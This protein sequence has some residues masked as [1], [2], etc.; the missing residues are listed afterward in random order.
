VTVSRIFPVSLTSASLALAACAEPDSI[1]VD[2][3][4][5]DDV[6]TVPAPLLGCAG[7]LADVPY[8][9]PLRDNAEFLDISYMDS[10]NGMPDKWGNPAVLPPGIPAYPGGGVMYDFNRADDEPAG[11]SS[12]H[13]HE[14]G[15]RD[16]MGNDTSYD[17]HNGYD[18]MPEP[19][20]VIDE[21]G[22]LVYPMSPGVVRDVRYEG[23]QMTIEV[24]HPNDYFTLYTHLEAGTERV[25]D[26][27]PV[28]LNTALAQLDTNIL[29]NGDANGHLHFEVHDCDPDWEPSYVEVFRADMQLMKRKPLYDSGPSDASDISLAIGDAPD[30]LAHDVFRVE[31]GDEL[32][33]RG[34][35]HW[36]TG[37]T[38]SVDVEDPNG[39][40]HG[41]SQA[42]RTDISRHGRFVQPATYTIGASD[43]LGLW[44]AR[45]TVNGRVRQ[46]KYFEVVANNAAPDTNGPVQ[47]AI[48]AVSSGPN[49]V[50]AY[51]RSTSGRMRSRVWREGTTGWGLSDH[52]GLSLAGPPSC[53]QRSA[54]LVDCFYR[55]NDQHFYRWASVDG[56]VTGTATD[57]Y[58]ASTGSDPEAFSAGPTSLEIAFND[59]GVMSLLH[60]NGS[61]FTKV[62]STQPVAQSPS[63]VVSDATHWLCYARLADTTAR[64]IRVTNGTTFQTVGIPVPG[65]HPLQAMLTRGTLAQR[66]L[67]TITNRW[68]TSMMRQ[69]QRIEHTDGSV[70]WL[71]VQGDGIGMDELSVAPRCFLRPDTTTPEC[72]AA[73]LDRDL[74]RIPWD[75]TRWLAWQPLEVTPNDKQAASLTALGGDRL[76]L[77]YAGAPYSTLS[78]PIQRTATAGTW[79]NDNWMWAHDGTFAPGCVARGGTKID[80]FWVTAAGSISRRTYDGSL[81]S[82][83]VAL[84]GTPARGAVS[85]V[86]RGASATTILYLDASGNLY[87][88]ALGDA[89]WTGA[90]SPVLVGKPAG[91]TLVDAPGC[92]NRS[93]IVPS[94]PISFYTAIDC[95]ARTADNQLA[96][97]TKG[98]ST[99]GAWSI[100]PGVKV[101]SAPSAVSIAIGRTDVFF[102]A[103]DN[104]LVQLTRTGGTYAAPVPL[105]G[106]I[107]SAP[108]CVKRTSPTRIDCVAQGFRTLAQDH[109]QYSYQDSAGWSLPRHLGTGLAN[110]ALHKPATQSSEYAP[111]PAPASRAVDGNLDGNFNNGS[112]THTDDT[113]SDSW[114]EVDLG[115]DTWID[116]L[117]V[118]NRT[119]AAQG[120]LNGF[121]YLVAADGGY[122]Y[123]PPAP[124]TEYP[125]SR[126]DPAYPATFLPIKR[127]I[128][129]IR[130]R[131]PTYLHVAEVMAMGREGLPPPF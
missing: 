126:T 35:G 94:L 17:A 14:V 23:G 86:A 108:A 31:R 104:G 113:S 115:A 70:R 50:R 106:A 103:P 25:R 65:T 51:Y 107:A 10:P 128:R 124:G 13:P 77:F 85:A 98:Q 27:D 93:V 67:V 97:I 110:L 74:V 72:F 30:T 96:T 87:E 43:P 9:Y 117:Q 8:Y 81:W 18:N 20:R 102:R 84:A 66:H 68:Q 71:T 118:Y 16:Y 32:H 26:G 89:G 36:R 5:G 119:D 58:A 3:E 57:I 79:S 44:K 90:S 1:S 33:V 111:N 114:W 82:T 46:V 100:V 75:G 53:V 69:H 92:T 47:S 63:C 40:L 78:G 56:G 38:I 24:T 121:S 4:V 15:Y 11:Y 6:T 41:V 54:T 45:T 112:V 7:Q 39:V 101:R 88:H 60:W 129:R 123:T 91:E 73:N 83:P 42:A 48:S 28:D 2:A 130:I 64:E 76:D 125:F 116:H 59:G 95:F 122:W 99:W 127:S 22:G 29:A 131:V 21:G 105:G 61:A 37:D 34:A 120:R 19:R 62:T 52:P 109:L 12:G 49:N 55:G 80:C